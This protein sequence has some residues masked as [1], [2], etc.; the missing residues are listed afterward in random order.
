M[1]TKINRKLSTMFEKVLFPLRLFLTTKV[2]EACQWFRLCQSGKGPSEIQHFK[3]ICQLC[4]CYSSSLCL[5]FGLLMSL[6]LLVKE[7]MDTNYVFF[8]TYFGSICHLQM[9]V[10]VLTAD[11]S[12]ILS[13]RK[14][15]EH[16]K[17]W[18]TEEE[19]N[20]KKE[21]ETTVFILLIF[22]I[23]TQLC[24]EILQT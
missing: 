16:L 8:V 24:R 15:F 19:H 7:H 18:G 9:S 12:W 20:R 4:A 1:K 3:R 21:Q 17:G 22:S 2:T 11:S 23:N 10:Y 13:E 5:L 6:S 14:T